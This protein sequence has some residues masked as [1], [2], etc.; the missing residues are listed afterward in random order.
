MIWAVLGAH[1]AARC[2][3]VGYVW[4]GL[5]R[6]QSDGW[7]TRRWGIEGG[8]GR[9]RRGAALVMLVDAVSFVV[10]CL[11]G[12]GTLPAVVPRAPAIAI[13]G[14]LV[15]LGLAAKLWA[16]ETLGAKAYYWYN[17][18]TPDTRLVPVTR[19]PFR[20]V[21]NPMYTVGYLQTYGLALITGSFA[22]LLASVCDQVAI[23][24]F[25]WRVERRHFERVTRLEA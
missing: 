24:L 5:A 23:L 18:F 19:G 25:H 15:V 10:V 8:F 16:A 20:Y 14:A 1:L 6:Q 13:G 3:Y 4:I 2:A 9:F 17:F 7:W 21:K 22:G 12:W 11:A